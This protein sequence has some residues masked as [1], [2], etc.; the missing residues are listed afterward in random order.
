LR[1]AEL[2]W[3]GALGG[4]DEGGGSVGEAGDFFLE[5]IGGAE[6][7]GDE[8]EAGLA[9]GEQRDLPGDAALGV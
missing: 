7:G 4:G 9:E 1:V 3:D 5:K 8:E 6:G 2:E